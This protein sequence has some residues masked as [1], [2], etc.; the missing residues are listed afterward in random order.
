MLMTR[1][2]PPAL[3]FHDDQGGGATK[4]LKEKK[5]SSHCQFPTSEFRYR[6]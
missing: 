3:E 4:K 1:K 5:R 6:W 2:I